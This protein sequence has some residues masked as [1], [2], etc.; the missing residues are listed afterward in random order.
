MLANIGKFYF[1]NA[2][3]WL[4]TGDVCLHFEINVKIVKDLILREMKCLKKDSHTESESK[5][6]HEKPKISEQ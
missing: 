4:Q 5:H 3:N 2:F 1:S 6:I